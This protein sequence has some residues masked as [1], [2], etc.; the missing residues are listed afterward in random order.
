MAAKNVSEEKIR[1]TVSTY[2]WGFVAAGAVAAIIGVLIL[3]WPNVMAGI[4]SVLI[5]IYALVS[6]VVF[7]AIAIRGVEA[8][9]PIRVAR[10]LVALALIIGGVMILLF[11]HTASA[12]M[13]DVIG[14]ALG[15]LWIF[16]GIMA[17][18][19]MRG[20]DLNFWLLAYLVV[21]IAMGVLML[22]TPVWGGWP[23]QWLF[24]LGLL[25]L[26]VA[27]VVRGLTADR[28]V[29]EVEEETLS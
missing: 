25:G 28:L 11:T 2:R 14:I 20:K 22:L 21:A 27:Q 15:I 17:A 29:V 13:V 4:F 18:L 23:L 1:V 3:I 19:L 16:E 10:G 26:G 9:L 6:G 8:P 7:G 24:G 12:V 5:A